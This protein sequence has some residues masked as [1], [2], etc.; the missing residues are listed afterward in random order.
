M[1]HLEMVYLLKM[2]IFHG[3]VRH[4]QM[5]IFMAMTGC[6]MSTS[7]ASPSSTHSHPHA[8]P[9]RFLDVSVDSVE[10][11]SFGFLRW[12]GFNRSPM[13]IWEAFI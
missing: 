12:G 8:I 5:V 3:H 9:D 2:E 11:D 7:T 6:N 4:N 1:A 10:R 13:T